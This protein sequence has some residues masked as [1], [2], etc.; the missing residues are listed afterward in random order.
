M[1][2]VDRRDHAARAVLA[3]LPTIFSYGQARGAGLS[4]RK[5]YW[6]RDHGLIEP[7]ARGTYRATHGP[8]DADAD[9]VEIASRTPKATICLASAL[10][11]HDLSDAI[12]TRI[13]IAIV[14]GQR[15]PPTSAPVIWHAFAADT[16]EIGRETIRLG[17][18]GGIGLYSAERSLVDAFRLRHQEGSDLAYEALRRWLRRGAS[19]PAELVRM[20]ERFPK[21]LP[22]IRGAL[23][24]LL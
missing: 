15:R 23:E 13:N 14:R 6:L 16:F 1:P 21:A 19:S 3:S 20:A 5:I 7:L 12:P 10:A 24:V 2:I 17:L 22:S 4:Q 8:I 11:R 9:L 18:D